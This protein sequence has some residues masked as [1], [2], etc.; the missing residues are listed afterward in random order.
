[1][2][3][4][5][6]RQGDKVDFICWKFYG[7]ERNGSVEAV[8]AANPGLANRGTT[9]EAGITIILPP[10]PEATKPDKAIKLWD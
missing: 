10:L 3:K 6:T 1:M 8:F 2:T 4:Y 5:M 7:S 9:L